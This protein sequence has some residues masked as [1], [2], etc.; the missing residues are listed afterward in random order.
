M[1]R[2]LFF[3]IL[4]FFANSKHCTN[5]GHVVQVV[6]RCKGFKGNKLHQQPM[7]GKRVSPPRWRVR[8]PASNLH[9]TFY[10]SGIR[11]RFSS[12]VVRS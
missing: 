11:G 4:S 7:A 3:W 1:I 12:F 2:G 6:G 10:R 9:E 8:Y 5:N